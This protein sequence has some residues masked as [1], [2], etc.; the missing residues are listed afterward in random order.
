[1]SLIVNVGAF[2]TVI[3]P[4]WWLIAMF[5]MGFIA[6]LCRK[7]SDQIPIKH[8]RLSLLSS[9]RERL[10]LMLLAYGLLTFVDY[11]RTTQGATSFGFANGHYW[12]RN[13]H[14]VRAI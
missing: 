1:M 7:A 11:Y 6:V 14:A 8:R 5:L 4:G 10:Q 13:K 9:P 2:V 12:A 3:Q